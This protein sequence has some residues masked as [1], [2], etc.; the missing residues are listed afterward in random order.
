[1][2]AVPISKL[3]ENPLFSDYF[4]K[5]K[6]FAIL[7]EKQMTFEKNN[8]DDGCSI[9]DWL[10]DLGVTQTVVNHIGI[11]PLA[12]L[13]EMDIECLYCKNGIKT[14]NE[15]FNNLENNSLI[16]IDKYNMGD[17]VDL[18]NGCQEKC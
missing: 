14:L 17:I 3:G 1:M 8:C 11:N 15:L 9:V 18:E 6:W 5:S 10:Y 16:H 2:L 12:K 7:D 13:N 4:G